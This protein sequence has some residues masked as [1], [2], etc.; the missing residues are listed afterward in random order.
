MNLSEPSPTGSD[1]LDSKHGL[2][3]N[4][5]ST[6]FAV[7]SRLDL[8]RIW[9]PSFLCDTILIPFELLG[10]D[11]RFYSVD[12][13]LQPDFEECEFAEGDAVCVISY[14]GFSHKDAIY[15][16]LAS[17]GVV[18]IED[19]C[20][21]FYQQPNP[22]ADF[23]VKSLRKFFAVP[24]GGIIYSKMDEKESWPYEEGERLDLAWGIEAITRRALYDH[25]ATDS[26][27]WYDCFQ[28]SEALMPVGHVPMSSYTKIQAAYVIDFELEAQKR[29][30]NFDCL[31]SELS[32]IALFAD[33]EDTVPIGFPVIVEN[34]DGVRNGLYDAKIYPPVHWDISAVIPARFTES[35][36]LSKRIMTL[37]CD[38]RYDVSDMERI[39]KTLKSLI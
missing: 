33:R 36:G 22:L 9:L 31:L 2:Y 15:E 23:S 17:C 4:V 7:V 26:T 6:F 10:V 19:L 5:R 30:A 14:F 8:K 29:A 16:Y 28:K 20:Q 3:A 34:R 37:P 39:I 24:D 21:A 18:V 11:C 1:L 35:H 12:A 32:G 38:G 13:K 27:S 25:G